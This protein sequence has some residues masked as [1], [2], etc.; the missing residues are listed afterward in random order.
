LICSMSLDSEGQRDLQSRQK[1]RTLPDLGTGQTPYAVGNV[2][3]DESQ[4][5][6]TARSATEVGKDKQINNANDAIE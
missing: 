6:P 1:R 5:I 2:E 4:G 3:R